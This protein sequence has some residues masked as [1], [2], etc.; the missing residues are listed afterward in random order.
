LTRVSGPTTEE[1][2][3]LLLAMASQRLNKSAEA[4]ACLER[5]DKAKP[6]DAAAWGRRLEYRLLRAEADELLKKK[7]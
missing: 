1:R 2:D 4:K 3:W 5:A 6:G 7:P